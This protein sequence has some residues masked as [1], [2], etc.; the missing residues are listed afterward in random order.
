M[1]IFV[2]EHC[3]FLDGMPLTMMFPIWLAYLDLIEAFLHLGLMK[4]SSMQLC[5]LRKVSLLMLSL[6][7]RHLYKKR[8]KLV[9]RT[10]PWG[11]PDSTGI[12]SDDSPSITIDW[13][14]S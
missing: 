3:I 8:N 6:L 2:I 12:L 13:L 9:P 10:E 7:V 14:R 11:T 5:R 4:L 1:V